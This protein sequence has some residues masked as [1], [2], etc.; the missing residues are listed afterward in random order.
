MRLFN[1]L[2]SVV[3]LFSASQFN[4]AS[5]S[6][7]FFNIPPNAVKCTRNELIS[8]GLQFDGQEWK[9]HKYTSRSLSEFLKIAP[10][11]VYEDIIVRNALA[12]VNYK[13]ITILHYNLLG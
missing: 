7:D 10:P 4:H 13:I 5:N 9:E 6:S 11:S 1:S 2:L 3:A 12:V 8:S